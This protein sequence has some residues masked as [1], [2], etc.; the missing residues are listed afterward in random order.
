MGPGP[1]PV[2]DVRGI[3][4]GYGSREVI[5][6]LDVTVR[7]GEILAVT[8]PNGS[9]KST[10]LRGLAGFQGMDYETFFIDDDEA[11]PSSPRHR[12]LTYA[13]LDEWM[14]LRDLT[15]RD[16]FEVFAEDDSLASPEEAL[17]AFGVLDLADRVPHSLSSGQQRRAALASILIRPWRVLFIDEPEQRLDREFQDVL[18][19]VFR[20]YL[21]DRAAVIATHAAPLFG[22]VVSQTVELGISRG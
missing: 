5:R 22:D 8:G 20:T 19:S 6:G 17:G 1:A 4:A 3:R 21:G 12:D 10:L 18:A 13:V 14:W 11:P 9:G 15:I 7:P 2:L 16:H